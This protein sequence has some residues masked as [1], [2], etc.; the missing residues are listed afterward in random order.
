ME[1]KKYILE[2]LNNSLYMLRDLDLITQADVKEISGMILDRINVTKKKVDI[3]I[4]TN[5]Y[6]Q[7]SSQNEW[8]TVF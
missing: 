1:L 2:M 5:D 6:K 3:E 7:V 8:D 4:S